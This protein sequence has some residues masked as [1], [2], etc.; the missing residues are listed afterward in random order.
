MVPIHDLL[1]IVEMLCYQVPDPNCSIPNYLRIGRTCPTSPLRFRPHFLPKYF[2]F[3]QVSHIGVVPGSPS[4][5][6]FMG[7][8]VHDNVLLYVKNTSDF[9]FF[10]AF[11]SNMDHAPIH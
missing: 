10:P 7:L 9:G 8:L 6:F 1:A 3:P 5:N 2:W 11:L 4:F